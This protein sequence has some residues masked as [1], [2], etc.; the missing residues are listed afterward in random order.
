[1]SENQKTKNAHLRIDVKLNATIINLNGVDVGYYHLKYGDKN[2]KRKCKELENRGYRCTYGFDE[3][4][5]VV[6]G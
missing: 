1:M 6:R 2:L 5:K 4:M 3:F